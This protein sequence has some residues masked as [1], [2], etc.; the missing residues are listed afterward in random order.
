MEGDC[1]EKIEE[2]EGRGRARGDFYM[3]RKRRR[4]RA[5]TLP[6]LAGAKPGGANTTPEIT[7]SSI[8]LTDEI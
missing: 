1:Q 4:A 3:T 2:K 6:D 7:K 5:R 8:S